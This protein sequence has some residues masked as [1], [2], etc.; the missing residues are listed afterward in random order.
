MWAVVEALL[1]GSEEGGEVVAS[2]LGV[3][4]GRASCEGPALAPPVEG[5]SCSGVFLSLC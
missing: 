4:G 5:G 1:A 3:V 2:A